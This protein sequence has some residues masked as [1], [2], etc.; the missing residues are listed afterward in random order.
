MLKNAK[1]VTL[2]RIAFLKEQALIARSIK[3]DKDTFNEITFS[4]QSALVVNV[5]KEERFYLR[6]Y[7]AIER[8]IEL[9]L[10]RKSEHLFVPQLITNQKRKQ[11]LEQDQE[12]KLL[13]EL[14]S[15]TTIDTA[16]FESVSYDI[17]STEFKNKVKPTLLLA[18]AV[19]LGGIMGIIVLLV[20]NTLIKED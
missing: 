20:R 15:F 6:G 5:N 2:S 18:L 4:S 13:T 17:V 11:E 10:K 12:I 8:E 16:A 14:R 7:I 19:F 1:L 3:L 9:L